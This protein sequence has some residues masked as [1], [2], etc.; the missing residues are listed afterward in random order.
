MDEPTTTAHHTPDIE[1]PG[2]Y[3]AAIPALLA[4]LAAVVVLASLSAG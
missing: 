1:I 4:A 2:W 3:A